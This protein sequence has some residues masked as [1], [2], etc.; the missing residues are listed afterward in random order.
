MY[1]GYYILLIVIIF[2]II[3][4]Y[5]YKKYGFWYYQPVFHYYDLQYWLFSIGVINKE[6][7]KPN[8]FCNFYNIKSLDFQDVSQE[9]IEELIEFT[10]KYYYNKNS[11]KYLPSKEKLTSYFE[12]NN[13]K[14]II[15][16]YKK[17]TI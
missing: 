14:S 15:S 16:F 6:M 10:Q 5:I 8:K 2:L 17:V 3:K 4:F 12:S 1:I 11:C 7:P 9:E 13:K